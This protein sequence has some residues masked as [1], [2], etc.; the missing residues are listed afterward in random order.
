MASSD[1][2]DAASS[3]ASQQTAAAR[4]SAQLQYDLGKEQL[5]FQREYYNNTLKPMQERDLKLREDLQAELL[6]SLKQQRQFADEQNQYYK[7]T[8]KPVEEQMVRDATGYDSQENIQR[9]QGIAAASVNQAFSNASGQ[10]LRAV[11]RLGL[12]PNSSAFAR[13]NA[14][15]Y[16]NEALASAGAQTGA[17]FD[18]MDKA[19]ALRAGAANFG[20]NMPNTAANYYG[21]GNQTAGTSSGVSSAGVN[22]AVNAVTPGLQGAQIASGAFRG[23]GSTYNDTFANNMRMYAAN[24]QGISGFFGGLGNFASSKLGQDA[25]GNLGGRIGGAWNDFT[26]GMNGGFGTGNAYGN[27]DLGAFL[28]DGGHVDA[29]RMGYANGG[30]VRGPGGPVDD[31][32]PAMLSDGEYVIPADVVKA[33]GLEFFDK[34]KEKYHTPAVLQRRGIGRA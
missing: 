1:A 19:I 21:L 34:L 33:K 2:T 30:K 17:A 4:D 8:F 32:V 7:E 23:A 9:R 28:A 27:Q 29:K 16:N 10:G 11:S 25:L 31:K 5:E 12:N 14:K 18:T 20:R 26:M 22:N 3:A 24:Q 6:P 13:E 15:L